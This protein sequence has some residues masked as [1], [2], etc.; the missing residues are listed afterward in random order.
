[1]TPVLFSIIKNC[2]LPVQSSNQCLKDPMC[3]RSAYAVS[4]QRKP[5]DRSPR[6]SP[7]AKRDIV[8]TISVPFHVC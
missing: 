1:M 2:K 4:I 6:F 5:A 3:S 7:I 8:R